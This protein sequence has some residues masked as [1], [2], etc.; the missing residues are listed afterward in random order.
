MQN[1]DVNETN[2]QQQKK[3]HV[4]NKKDLEESIIYGERNK[5]I[6]MQ[7]KNNNVLIIEDEVKVV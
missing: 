2:Q 5:N 1:L 4:W 6:E 7:E 3:K